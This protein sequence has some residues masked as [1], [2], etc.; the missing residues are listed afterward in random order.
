MNFYLGNILFVYI[1]YV[2]IISKTFSAKQKK[3]KLNYTECN[4]YINNLDIICTN[5]SEDLFGTK[6]CHDWSI[7][8]QSN[9]IYL[10]E[11]CSNKTYT[12]EE[13]IN[14]FINPIQKHFNIIITNNYIIPSKYKSN[15][16]KYKN[17]NICMKVY[18][19]ISKECSLEEED[20]E[21]CKKM[22]KNLKISDFCKNI[23]LEMIEEF[24]N[25]LESLVNRKEKKEV[26]ILENQESLND[27]KLNSFSDNEPRKECVEYG[28]KSNEE[29]FCL[30]YE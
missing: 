10:P 15:S 25:W 11:E 8:N 6:I 26:I 17:V 27:K 13:P 3:I 16:S 9:I 12:I 29:I 28:L 19:K 1:F 2:Y 23:V 4:I 21:N 24:Q 30:K 7:Y 18:T 5:F 20:S 14:K 22:Q